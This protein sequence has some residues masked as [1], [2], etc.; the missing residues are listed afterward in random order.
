[1][2]LPDSMGEAR[3]KSKARHLPPLRTCKEFAEEFGMSVHQ[4]AATLRN[5]K[6]NPP[7]PILRNRCAAGSTHSTWYVPAEMRAWW[8]RHNEMKEQPK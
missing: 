2:K 3:R 8:K 4:L 1:M 7:E 5:S 6:A